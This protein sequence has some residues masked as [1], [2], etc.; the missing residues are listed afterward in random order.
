MKKTKKTVKCKIF[1]GK[2]GYLLQ[3]IGKDPVMLETVISDFLEEI[4]KT[5]QKGMRILQ[6]QSGPDG[7]FVTISIFYK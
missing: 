1:T 7:N 5:N 6:S 3:G 4:G 2:D